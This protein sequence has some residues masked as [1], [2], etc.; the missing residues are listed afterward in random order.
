M[1]VEEPFALV[2]GDHEGGL[3]GTCVIRGCIPKKIMAYGSEYS[4]LHQESKAFGWRANP[5]GELSLDWRAFLSAKDREVKR[6]E[7]LYRRVVV[8]CMRP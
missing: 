5:H 4:R 6:L 2:P 7:E 1:V 3:G 8:G